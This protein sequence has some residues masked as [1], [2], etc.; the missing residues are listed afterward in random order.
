[1][2]VTVAGASG[3]VGKNLIQILKKNHKIIGLS[4]S[5]KKSDENI[6]WRETDL[7]S[8][9]STLKSLEG[10]D[11]AIYLVHSML[12][13]SKLF[14]GSFRDTD[15][16]LADNFAKACVH[17]GV[18]QIIYLGGLVPSHGMSEHLESRREVED[19]LKATKIPVTV[20]RAGMV[21]GEGGSSF[22][23]LRNLVKNLPFMVLPHW[24]QSSTQ[25]IFIDDLVNV[26]SSSINNNEFL[27]KTI[28]VVNGEAINYEQLIKKTSSY[29][30]KGLV[31]VH[32]PINYTSFSKLWVKLFGETD[33]ELVSPLIDSL[34]CDLPTPSIPKEIESIIEYRSFEEMLQ[35]IASREEKT[36]KRRGS[37][38]E[39]TVRSI[40]RLS[41]PNHLDED[42]ICDEY[43]N[44]LPRYMQ[45][46]ISAQ[47]LNHQVHFLMLGLS[48]PLLV[49]EKVDNH[50][51]LDRVKFH[52]V[53]GI[54]SKTNDTGWLEFRSIADGKYTL[55]SINEFVPSLP[56]YLYKYTQALAHVKV[57]RAF[58]KYLKK[59]KKK[60]GKK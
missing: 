52:I 14:Q 16:L 31:T 12:P 44:W 45:S 10:S 21:V 53:G 2:K 57:M 35:K 15:L 56:W 50:E 48:R 47:K 33:Y 29:F 20:F 25:V 51:P 34:L 38:S 6:E 27:N 22:E 19:V 9:Q 30:N 49:L 43:L 1:M 42:M 4:R 36:G 3:F 23:I 17:C 37:R 28:D 8:F 59:K 24:T 18:K 55:A 11:V 41:N 32:V 58:G 5:S 46:L 40:Q 39:N 26:I 60:K 54:L 7:F 13:S